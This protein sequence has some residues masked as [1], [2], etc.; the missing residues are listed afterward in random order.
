[1]CER[2]GGGYLFSFFLSNARQCWKEQAERESEREREKEKKK[3]S[4]SLVCMFPCMLRAKI[5]IRLTRICRC[6]TVTYIS[7]MI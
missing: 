5:C 1:M 2:E 4:A 6:H 3:R 7:E